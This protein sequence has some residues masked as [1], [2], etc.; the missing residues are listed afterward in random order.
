MHFS[1]V[2]YFW[3]MA[4]PHSHIY[5]VR[6]IIAIVFLQEYPK[7]LRAC[8]ISQLIKYPLFS[9]SA[10]T[11]ATIRKTLNG[12]VMYFNK[13]RKTKFKFPFAHADGETIPETKLRARK[14]FAFLS[15]M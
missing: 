3:E 15:A 11:F 9:T 8:L 13:K 2:S 6:F 4:F 12:S 1:T 14:S 7:V 5:H 10:K